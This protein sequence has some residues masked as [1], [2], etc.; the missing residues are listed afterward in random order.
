M[1]TPVRLEARRVVSDSIRWIARLW[2]R[3][4]G[5]HFGTA[6]HDDSGEQSSVHTVKVE[7]NFDLDKV[8]TLGSGW[9]SNPERTTIKGRC[10]ECWGRLIGKLNDDGQITG[11]KCRVCDKTLQGD[12]ARDEYA[13]LENEW[14]SNELNRRFGWAPSYAADAIFVRKILPEQEPLSNGE[15]TQR[16]AQ[17]KAVPKKKQTKQLS[18]HDFPPGSPGFF[19]LQAATLMAG[20]EGVSHP[21][22]WSVVDLPDV[23]FGDDGTAVVTMS[24]SGL[25][26]DP[27]FEERR[28]MQRLGQTMTAAMIS[29]FA[30]ELAMK[31]ITLTAKD[32]AAKTHDLLDLFQGL[33]GPSRRR[34]MAD[35][36]E[37]EYVLKF[38]RQTFG[39]WR[40]FE[41]ASSDLAGQSMVNTEQARNL[42]KAARVILDEAEMMGL[43]YTLKVDAKHHF[44][45]LTDEQTHHLTL[46]V[47]IKGHE[48][49]PKNDHSPQMHAR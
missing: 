33:P 37:I 2:H 36:P 8:T 7:W 26:D 11:I 27:Q 9:D 31:A 13:R 48:A 41:T 32:M 15:I 14:G 44:R 34:I 38:G 1:A 5:L 16:I 40:Y 49:P 47:N 22:A 23:R 12:S 3:V 4:I 43:G 35:Y 18:R 25:S 28:L 29:A 6:Q 19:V 20:V 30:C 46:N 42:G 39:M 17:A 21:S 24:T 45:E 10:A